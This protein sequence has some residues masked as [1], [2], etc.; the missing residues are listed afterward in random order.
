MQ[1]LKSSNP[2]MTATTLGNA[3]QLVWQDDF[4]G[5]PNSM[6]DTTKWR[7]DIGGHGWGNLEWQYYTCEPENV[8]LDGQGC[9]VITASNTTQKTDLP[10]AWY[11]PA[12]YLS[13]RLNTKSLFEFLYGRIEARMKIPVGQGIWSALWLLGSDIDTTLW[14]RCGEIDVM[15]NIGREPNIIYGS[16]H[17]PSYSR[18][19]AFSQAY[20]LPND[21]HFSREFHEFAVEWRPDQIRWFVDKQEFF[22]FSTSDLADS[23]NWVF[24]RPYFVI[25]NVAVGG[26]WPGYPDRTTRFPQSML[27][28]YVRVYQ[29][30]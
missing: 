25:L 29:S 3:W 24:N 12:R 4:D 2:L 21:Q 6:P 7:C 1:E 10:E 9:L 11:G 18:L 15:E 27:V 28:D 16:A 20:Q 14:P 8:S 23:S 30:C 5:P 26:L 19:Q 17:G 22:C 13:A